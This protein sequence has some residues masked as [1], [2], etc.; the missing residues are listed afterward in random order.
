MKKLILSFTTLV[1]LAF[2]AVAPKA[3]EAQWVGYFSNGAFCL[4]PEIGLPLGYVNSGGILLGAHGEVA[5]TRAGT[6]GD[7]R[8]AIA[9]GLDYWG[10]SAGDYS[11][12]ILPI[13]A[14]ANYHFA[15]SSKEWDPYVGIGLGLAIVS[16]SGTNIPTG[17]SST[18]IFVTVDG[19][20]RYWFSP[21]LALR[22]ELGLGYASEF[23]NIGLDFELN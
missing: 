17:G 10:V 21:T 7:G 22:G 1:L 19:G 12:T 14:I 11:I 9:F 13:R 23:L 5:V 6:L 16:Y 3:A 2:I 18:P 15:L 4:G 8:L 20:V